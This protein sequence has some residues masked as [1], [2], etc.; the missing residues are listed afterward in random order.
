MDGRSDYGRDLNVDLTRESE[1]TGGIIGVQV[2][3][4]RSF[5]KH[6]QWVIPASPP[7]WE[8]WRS[9]NVPIVGMV[10]DPDRNTIRWCNLTRLAR[11]QVMLDDSYFP[12][13]RSDALGEVVVTQIL[14]DDTFSAFVDEMETYLA[15][16]ADSAYLLLL[17]AD[18]EVRRHGVFNCWTLGRHDARPLV[19]LRHLLSSL[20]NRS[21]LDAIQVL[22]HAT[23][24]P[25]IFWT[26]Q[27][28]I[29]PNVE[30]E[31]RASFRWSSDELFD[32]VNAVE[33]M[34]ASGVDWQR[35]GVG[36]SLWSIMV[37][38]P[39]LCAN[40]PA[41]IRAA[42]EAG[43]IQAAVRLVI[44]YQYLTDDPVTD[45]DRIM[46]A[47]PALAEDEMA[48]WVVEE[49]RERGRFNVY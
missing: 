5:F 7:D 20:A 17:D 12:S 2:K 46:R 47:H 28:W 1:V 6:G 39:G 41:G 29:S 11:S 14:D 21:L 44:C 49:L 8:Y 10:H 45:V 3:G 25:D 32:L 26:K 37:V 33:T 36:Q 30:R 35:G 16:T 23:A 42:V 24:H 13:R 38:D 9:S 19:L 34:D 15:A 4:G 22:A 31:V 18:D 27:N 48:G 43:R 40:L